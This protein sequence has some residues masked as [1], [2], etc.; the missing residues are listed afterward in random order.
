[1]TPT[2]ALL[3]VAALPVAALPAA[4]PWWR[5]D[6]ARLEEL[7]RQVT[8]LDPGA[9]WWQLAA[10]A[11]AA[12]VG[13]AHAL[14]PGHGKLLV[15]AYLAGTRGRRRDALAL[16]VLV[17]VM[18]TGSVVALAL[19]LFGVSTRAAVSGQVAQVLATLAGLG[20]ATVGVVMLVRQSSRLVDSRS[21]PTPDGHHHHPHQP[22]VGVAPLSRTGL[23]ALAGAG[24]LLPSPA[25][26]LVLTTAFA[27]DR[28]GFGLALVAMFGVGLATTLAL[29]GLAVVTGRAALERAALRRPGWARWLGWLP[30]VT[31]A[32]ITVGGLWLAWN[33]ISGSGPLRTGS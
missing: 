14:G 18:H 9:V 10:L 17:A 13:M 31:A 32:V 27:I 33:G 19:V 4:A 5:M 16:G 8:A 24:G 28:A 15:G 22:P 29:T 25:A 12:L 20:V 26:F 6:D 7:A 23:V 30:I 21:S 11:I 1:V 3:P 2:A